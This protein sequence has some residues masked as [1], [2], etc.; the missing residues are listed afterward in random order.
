[1]PLMIDPGSSWISWTAE[2]LEEEADE[3]G[4]DC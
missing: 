2:C 1:M 3:E 4:V